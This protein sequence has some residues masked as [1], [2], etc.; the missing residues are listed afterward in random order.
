MND[1]AKFRFSQ[2]TATFPEGCVAFHQSTCIEQG[3]IEGA[4]CIECREFAARRT[5]KP[6]QRQRMSRV[7]A[8]T[9]GAFDA[10]VADGRREVAACA[11]D[12]ADV[13]DQETT[14]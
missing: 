3:L 4:W 6:A 13:Q 11:L 5:T 10:G 8:R 14:T 7:C 1:P 9:L 12:P 2:L